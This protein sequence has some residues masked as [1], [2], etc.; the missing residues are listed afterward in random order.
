MR[1]RCAPPPPAADTARRCSALRGACA[2]ADAYSLAYTHLL[3]TFLAI[4]VLVSVVKTIMNAIVFFMLPNISP[5]LRNKRDELVSRESAFR[6]LGMRAAIT[7]A[8]FKRLSETSEGDGVNLTDLTMA[9]GAVKDATHEQV[10]SE[11]QAMHIAKTILGKKLKCLDFNQFMTLTEGSTL[12]FE[13]YLKLVK[14]TADI[15][16][17]DKITM[18]EKEDAKN[19]Y[20][21][22]QEGMMLDDSDDGTVDA[23]GQAAAPDTPAPVTP[24]VAVTPQPVIAPQVAVTPQPVV[25]PQVMMQPVARPL[26]PAGVIRVACYQCTRHFGVPAGARMV[27]CPH[28]GATNDVGRVSNIQAV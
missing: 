26:V 12:T 14:R 22:V 10:V 5:I 13:R 7:V 25:A 17:F 8:Q 1:A 16:G 6:E 19:A 4:V 23:Q 2:R 24:Q 9:F 27:R 11:E 15:A 21:K 28:C 20:K 3:E 18:R